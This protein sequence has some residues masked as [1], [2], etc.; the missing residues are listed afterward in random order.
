MIRRRSKYV[1]GRVPLT[2][3]SLFLQPLYQLFPAPPRR[4]YFH[5]PAC[6]ECTAN[7]TECEIYVHVISEVFTAEYVKFKLSWMTGNAL[8][9]TVTLPVSP[10]ATWRPVVRSKTEPWM[11]LK[12]SGR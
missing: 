9:G 5:R 11:L 10:D 1:P 3:V 8:A 4:Q 12:V 6:T 7:G 2:S